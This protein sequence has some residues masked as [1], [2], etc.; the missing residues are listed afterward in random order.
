MFQRILQSI[1]HQNLLQ[2]KKWH[3]K[4]C[5]AWYMICYQKEQI[6]YDTISYFFILF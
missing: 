6:I 2:K 3:K 4:R 1:F 5:L